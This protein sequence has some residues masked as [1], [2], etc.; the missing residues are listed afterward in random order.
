MMASGISALGAMVIDWIEGLGRIVLF[1]MEALGASVRQLRP[2]RL[3]DEIYSIGVLSLSV[4]T[5]SGAAVGAVLGLIGY[6]V[7][8]RFGAEQNLGALVSI[9]LIKEL[10]PVLTGLL[11]AGRAGSAVAGEIGSMVATEQLDGIRMMAMD[12][13]DF[14]VAPKLISFILVMPLLSALFIAFGLTGGYV[15]GAQLL[16]V[17]PGSYVSGIET[18]ISFDDEVA[19]SLIKAFVFGTIV[20]LISTYRGYTAEPNV[21]GVSRATTASVV[22]S[23]VCVLIADYFVTALWGV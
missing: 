9:A 16:G 14:V 7:L 13:V 4:I 22:A 18:N 23:S 3:L 12:P 8:N 2:R 21:V 1:G 11:V 5:I 10:G 20:G 17:D 6:D 19:M 15:I